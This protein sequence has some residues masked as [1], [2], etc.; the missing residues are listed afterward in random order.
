MKLYALAIIMTIPLFFSNCR[1]KEVGIYLPVH[2]TITI[3]DTVR[4][5]TKVPSTTPTLIGKWSDGVWNT[6]DP[7]FS[8]DSID[9]DWAGDMLYLASKDSIYLKD[10]HGHTIY[11]QYSYRI[12]AGNDTLWLTNTPAP[13]HPTTVYWR[14][15]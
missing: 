2:D 1:K 10:L 4:D 9:W 13:S 7:I 8:K 14:V 5:T 3:R 12:S 15:N 6:P 11:C